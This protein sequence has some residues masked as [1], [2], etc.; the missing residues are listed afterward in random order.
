MPQDPDGGEGVGGLWMG[1]DGPGWAH[2]WVGW[3]K[4][5]PDEPKA[6]QWAQGPF[7]GLPKAGHTLDMCLVFVQNSSKQ[8]IL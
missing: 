1:P 8:G 5:G 3:A 7:L 4:T 6:G 2:G